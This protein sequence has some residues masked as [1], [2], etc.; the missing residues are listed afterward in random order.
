MKCEGYTKDFRAEFVPSP[1]N[2]LDVLLIHGSY[3]VE[4]V[5]KCTTT[6]NLQSV[7]QPTCAYLVYDIPNIVFIDLVTVHVLKAR[8]FQDCKGSKFYQSPDESTIP[9][10]QA[11]QRYSDEVTQELERFGF[12]VMKLVRSKDVHERYKLARCENA[13][14]PYLATHPYRMEHFELYQF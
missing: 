8:W 12:K 2:S 9:T 7:L 6:L 10:T 4:D 11:A 5:Q 14:L 13:N 3:G 1:T